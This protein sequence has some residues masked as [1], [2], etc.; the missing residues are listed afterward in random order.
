MGRH[1]KP[2]TDSEMSAVS[3]DVGFAPM[4]GRHEAQK[5][6]PKSAE[7]RRK[8]SE[9]GA[10]LAGLLLLLAQPRLR[11]SATFQNWPG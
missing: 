7:L 11:R 6:S 9:M 4:N 5:P 3:R 8:G 1:P 2:F 10:N